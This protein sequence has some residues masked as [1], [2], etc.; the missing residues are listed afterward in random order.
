MGIDPGLTTG[1]GIVEERDGKLCAEGFGTIKST[2]ELPE[3]LKMIYDEMISLIDLHRPEV[4]AIE[5][6]F[7]Y[8]N[9]KTAISVGESRGVA[10]LAAASRGKEIA[11]YTPLQVKQAVVGYGR[12]EKRQVQYMVS[13]LLSLDE[14]PE[15]DAADAMA[16]AICHI[17]FGSRFKGTP[18]STSGGSI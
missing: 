13:K 4:V 12:A 10:V 18:Q 1:Y 9:V 14:R 2:G 17:H 16:I 6:L 15:E 7:V 5:E 8:K 11:E 3:R